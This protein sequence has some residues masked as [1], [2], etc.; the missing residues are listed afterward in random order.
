[1][2]QDDS[3]TR[4]TPDGVRS[5]IVDFFTLPRPIQDRVVASLTGHGVPGVLAYR[6]VSSWTVYRWWLAAALLV[7]ALVAVGAVDFG[8][9]GSPNALH[10]SSWGAV[11]VLLGVALG[12]ACVGG[13]LAARP[14]DYPFPL[15]VY[16]L[17]VGVLAVGRRQLR[18]TPMTT[19]Q[20]VEAEGTQ[21]VRLRFEGAT[22]SFPL[23]GG[24]SVDGLRSDLE[25]YKEQWRV[26]FDAGDRRAL[27][28]LDPI[29]DSGFSNPLS[30]RAALPRVR[31]RATPR[32]V[33]GVLL[34]AAAG[35]GFF[36]ARNALA[37]RS[38]YR[39]AVAANDEAAY[40]AYIAN[41]GRRADVTEVRLPQAELLA[42]SGNLEAVEK[43]ADEH[44]G[45]KIEDDI[46]KLL[47]V[48][49]IKELHRI[50]AASDLPALE[51]FKEKHRHATLV[52]EELLTVRKAVYA[53]AIDAF[54]RK[55]K[56]TD[57]AARFFRE[58]VRFA[59]QRG[60]VVEL[61]IRRE[62]PASIDRADISVRKS[63]YFTGQ[64][65]V[66]SQYFK[67][68]PAEERE[69]RVLNA[70]AGAL[71]AGFSPSILRFVVR[72]S[73]EGPMDVEASVDVPTVIV[74]YKTEM[75]GGYT[76][77][78]PRGVY[79]G[80]GMMFQAA[81]M[82]PG[83]KGTFRFK[84]SSWLPPDINE[85]SKNLL[86]PDQVY[87]RNA[88][89]GFERFLNRL[90]ERLVGTQPGLRLRV[91]A[92]TSRTESNGETKLEITEKR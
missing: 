73:E 79:V 90:V 40:R 1:M 11:Y 46:Q 7:V 49:L 84:D 64:K 29:R 45:S 91:D 32:V 86:R 83:V 52:E 27:A 80:L 51:S 59:E 92:D 9:L 22:F 16:L 28:G 19:L 30:S 66:P 41:G 18:M 87:E 75:S 89:E 65:A 21:A 57:D 50:R 81:A 74:S 55:Y 71:Q 14:S 3:Q 60:P 54:M 17:P 44:P 23:G 34:G 25:G 8:Q 37:E 38:I 88:S 24:T 12:L 70:L 82:V 78:R 6:S 2:A 47:R 72:S 76:T 33:L 67:G 58:A 53:E 85:I 77:N 26:A 43:Y 5:R 42:A 48:E 56:P 10:G 20:A 68:A 69:A 62:T 31:T 15:G 4:S 36:V 61:R 13:A 35:L 63:A 39:K